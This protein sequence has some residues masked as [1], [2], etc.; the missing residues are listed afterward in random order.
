VPIRWGND[1]IQRLL[2]E[3]VLKELHVLSV[4]GRVNTI[5]THARQRHRL[6]PEAIEHVLTLRNLRS[7]LHRAVHSTMPSLALNLPLRLLR[8]LLETLL[9]LGDVTSCFFLLLVAA[10]L[11]N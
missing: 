6:L 11:V 8:I 10:R 4:V 1:L 9:L 5:E 3:D 7:V 2:V